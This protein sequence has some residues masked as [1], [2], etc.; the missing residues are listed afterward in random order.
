[1]TASRAVKAPSDSPRLVGVI[2]APADLLRAAAL[3]R[4]PD[5]FELRL[6]ALSHLLPELERFLPRLR[7]PLIMTARHP[8]EGGR[9]QLTS[10][11]RGDLLARFLPISAAIDLELRST[12]S[13]RPLLEEATRRRLPR[14]ISLHDFERCPSRKQMDLAARAAQRLGADIFKLA[15]RTETKSELARLL[16]FFAAA[17]IGM[18]ISAMGIGKLGRQSRLELARRGSALNYVHLGAP[19]FVGQLSL[20]EMRRAL[21]QR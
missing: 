3:A 4:P 14:I 11:Q 12:A 18:A 2:S 20:E 17:K 6:D 13:M 21:A 5:Y 19:Q 15:V 1:M 7:A 8:R 9:G 16:E 10:R